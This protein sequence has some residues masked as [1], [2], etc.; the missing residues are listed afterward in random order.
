MPRV[1]VILPVYNGSRFVPEAIE[2]IL[3]QS[4][5]DFEFLIHDDGSTDDTLTV[6]ESYAA[7]DPRIR[8]TSAKNQGVSASRND[9]M[10]AAKGEYLAVMDH[11]DIAMPDRFALQVAH[12]DAN[13]DCAVVA[14]QVEW[15]DEDGLPIGQLPLPTDSREIEENLLRNECRIAHAAAMIRASALRAVGGYNAD[16][17]I[18]V[19][20]ELWLR[21]VEVGQ[22]VNLPD[23]MVKYRIVGSGLSGTKYARQQENALRACLAARRRRNL[24]VEEDPRIDAPPP[25]SHQNWEQFG[26][27][28]WR[29]GNRTAWRRYALR[30]LKASPFS[31]R[32]WRLLVFGAL[33]SP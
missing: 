32:A 9:L 21:I 28:A 5:T 27:I 15:I 30:A 12:L 3:S 11:D 6:V 2:S 20:Y 16:Y 10:A 31:H 29:S 1:S 24:P 13:P 23:L 14:G 33:R 17:S 19:D 22:I 8:V 25:A 4:F 18:A 26:W 7:K